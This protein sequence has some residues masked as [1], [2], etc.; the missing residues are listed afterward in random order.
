VSTREN[1]TQKAYRAIW[2]SLEFQSICKQTK[3]EENVRGKDEKG[4]LEAS[5][6]HSLSS[7][8]HKLAL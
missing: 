4:S 7:H 3:D 5:F 1:G 6:E 2:Q 8:G